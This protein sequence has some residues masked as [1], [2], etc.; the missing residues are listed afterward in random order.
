M[1]IVFLEPSTGKSSEWISTG[2]GTPPAA[3][4]SSQ[5]PDS[6]SKGGVVFDELAGVGV[7]DKADPEGD[8]KTSSELGATGV[9]RETYIQVRVRSHYRIGFTALWRM[10]CIIKTI[11]IML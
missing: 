9:S 1:I 8:N 4:T 5:K 11:M 6:P 2:K 7:A 3:S 10:W